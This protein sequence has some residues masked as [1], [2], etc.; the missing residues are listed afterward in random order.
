MS[1]SEEHTPA[2]SAPQPAKGGPWNLIIIVAILTVIAIV[3][4]PG[5]EQAPPQ[6]IPAIGPPAQGQ[7]EEPSLLQPNGPATATETPAPKE[8]SAG[9]QPSAQVPMTATAKAPGAAARELIAELRKQ[10]PPDLDRAFQAAQDHQ[11]AGRADDAYLLYFFAAREGHGKSAMALARQADP[12]S[13]EPGGLFDEADELQAHKW[14]SK[15]SEAGIA[16]ADNALVALHTQIEAAAG[17][18]DER[19]QRIMLQWK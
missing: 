13:F 4:V 17:G 14:Y 10:T 8:A 19:A 7:T 12:A 16:E 6:P 11:A 2:E 5:E 1:E 9:A 18:G 3:L 15:A